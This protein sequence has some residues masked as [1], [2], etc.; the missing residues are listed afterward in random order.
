MAPKAPGAPEAPR[1]CFCWGC[2]RCALVAT[3]SSQF[4]EMSVR[5]DLGFTPLRLMWREIQQFCEV[6]VSSDF[7]FTPIIGKL[8]VAA[9]AG[10]TQERLWR[11]RKSI[12][13]RS[14]LHHRQHKQLFRLALNRAAKNSDLHW[15]N[16]HVGHSAVEKVSDLRWKEEKPRRAQKGEQAK[17][18]LP[19]RW[20]V[21]CQFLSVFCAR[22]QKCLK[23]Q[24]RLRTEERGYIY[25]FSEGTTGSQRERIGSVVRRRPSRGAGAKRESEV[26]EEE[27]SAGRPSRDGERI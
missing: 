5:S 22:A 24:C 16:R 27:S 3:F 25:L 9:F 18:Y 2:Q 21:R 23:S 19:Q 8:S 7:W 14:D 17:E 26:S 15:K 1:L 20:Y 11:W 6:L 10:S 4:L 13:A 12:N